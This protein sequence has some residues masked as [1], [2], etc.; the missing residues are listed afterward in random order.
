M[1]NSRVSHLIERPGAGVT[2]PVW[3]KTAVIYQ[4]YPRS[5]FDTTGD[6]IGDLN[7]IRQKLSY[8]AD[9]GVG[10]IWLSP[11]FKSP[12]VDFGYDI[13][14]YCAIDPVFGSMDDFDLLL[15]DVH[16]TGLK[17]ILDLVPNHTS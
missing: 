14:D 13:S 6:G 2:D 16:R 7:G 10:A 3:W 4:I 9:L 5:F 11:I 15:N 1:V 12:M 17:L 8:L